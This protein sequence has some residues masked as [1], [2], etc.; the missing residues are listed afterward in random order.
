[1]ADA[2]LLGL[3]DIH[4]I[5][6]ISWWPPAIGWWLL[7]GGAL[8]LGY[9][10][11][12]WW[13][14]GRINWRSDARARLNEL[15]RRLDDD[16]PEVVLAELSIVLRRAAIARFGRRQCAGLT[17]RRWLSFLADHD[18]KGFDWPGRAKAMIDAPYAPERVVI[19]AETVVVLIK[20]ARHWVGGRPAHV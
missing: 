3:R 9:I 19:D 1:M 17:G 15:R 11:W 20:A 12:T 6:P 7:A 5:D 4:G 2:A 16:R 18:P 8:V 13:S 14:E 10:A